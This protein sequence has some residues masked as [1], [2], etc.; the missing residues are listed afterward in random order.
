MVTCANG[1]ANQVPGG[2][3]TACGLA[4]PAPGEQV[5]GAPAAPA[6]PAGEPAAFA[7][8][9]AFGPPEAFPDSVPPY[10]QMAPPA[11][12]PRRGRPWIIVAAVVVA[13]LV[14]G[15]VTY[16]LITKPIPDVTGM[17]TGQARSALSD[18][19]FADVSTANEFS[20]SVPRG[21][22]VSQEPGPGSR[23]RSGQAVSLVISRGEPKEVPSLV[24]ESVTSATRAVSGLDLEVTTSSQ[25]SDSVPEG[26]IIAQEPSPGAVL[27]EGDVVA[28]VVS[29]GPPNTTVTVTL[30][31]FTVVLDDVFTDCSDAMTI[32]QVY[33]QDSAIV[34]GG[35]S[36][37]STL[38]GTWSADPGNGYIFPCEATGT[39]PRT[40]TQEDAY[41]F[42]LN[43]S[44]GSSSGVSY[45]R[46]EMEANG[47]RISLGS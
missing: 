41:R 37:L 25:T 38:S 2:R 46:E 12:R 6:P 43:P 33:F 31:L 22:V 30:D 24:G 18:A 44:G 20:D 13:F 27:E 35:G 4:L 1:H 14:A 8:P 11:E 15:G 16:M 32:L 17:A 3:C 10:P 34:D 36:T 40:S 21:G 19:G 26:A 5:W 29:T 45:T 23:A 47:W 9:E 7:P 42:L 28:L 39:F